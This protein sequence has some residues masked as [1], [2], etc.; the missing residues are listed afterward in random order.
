MIWPHLAESSRIW[1]H[2]ALSGL[3]CRHLASSG[4]GG[5]NF[6]KNPVA[7]K[8]VQDDCESEWFEAFWGLGCP[9]TLLGGRRGGLTPGLGDRLG[10]QM[11]HHYM[12]L[13][14]TLRKDL[15]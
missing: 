15:G 5:W 2:L 9:G 3:F 4:F 14:P 11:E 13:P 6:P 7:K 1:R 12:E 10:Q 8:T